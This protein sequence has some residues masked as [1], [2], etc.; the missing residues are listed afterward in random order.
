MTDAGFLGWTRW[1]VSL[2]GL[3]YLTRGFMQ[4]AAS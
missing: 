4:L 3:L 2:I 1:I